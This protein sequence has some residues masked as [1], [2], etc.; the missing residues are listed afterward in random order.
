LRGR[1]EVNVGSA[2]DARRIFLQAAKDI[3]QV[4]PIRALEL[5]VAA[6]VMRTYGIADSGSEDPHPLPVG[7]GPHD[8]PRTRCMKQLVAAARLT[9]TDSWGGA[10]K[11]LQ[12]ALATG[13]DI[14]DLDL[15]GNLGNAALNL[16]D[17]EAAGRFYSA[18]LF[19]ARERGSGTFVVYAL[20]RLAFTQLLAGEWSGVAGSASEALALAR[21]MAQ[22]A[23]GAAPLAWL[24]LLAA[25]RGEDEYE[26]HLAE[27]ED[28][29]ASHPLGILTD[30]V[31]D[32]TRW[33]RA[34]RATR[35][36]DSAAAVH[37]LARMRLPAVIRM[38]ALDR[39]GAAVRAGDPVRAAGWVDEFAPFA[40]GTGWPWALAA[41]AHGR[42]LTGAP[43]E[44]SVRFEAALTHARRARRPY[45]E[46]R[47]QLAYGEHLR[48]SQHRVD[49]RPHIRSALQTFTD[50]SAE[51]MLE[52]AAQELR[53]SGETAR[54]RDPSTRLKLTPMEVKVVALVS[55][56]MSNKD[57]AAQCWVSPRTVEFHLRNV[58]SKAGVSS[59]AQVARLSLG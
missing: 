39:F 42:A 20:Q 43:G 32:L 8:A 46:A 47:T 50:L 17:D 6:S 49:A 18:M 1:I 37:H 28:V 52:H 34:S 57:I 31:H 40:E 41:L 33:A 51:P 44:R 7:L 38:A 29:T 14:D 4:D 25:L 36:G 15:L 23:L 54:K 59:R 55:S 48:R 45:D 26:H 16:G 12:E 3:A 9:A 21:T 53:A 13:R 2:S 58:F 30:P 10:L 19:R 22:P 27:L 24:T 35:N 5:E 56:G 11:Q